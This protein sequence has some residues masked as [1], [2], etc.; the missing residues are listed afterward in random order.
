MPNEKSLA[1]KLTTL[2]PV[3]KT[4]NYFPYV[5]INKNGQ[6][7][8][9]YKSEF[10]LYTDCIDLNINVQSLPELMKEWFL[11]DCLNYQNVSEFLQS[12]GIDDILNPKQFMDLM[13]GKAY[14]SEPLLKFVYEI[15]PFGIAKD[16]I[17]SLNNNASHGKNCKYCIYI[18][19]EAMLL[20]RQ[21]KQKIKQEKIRLKKLERYANLKN[22]R[23]QKLPAFKAFNRHKTLCAMGPGFAIK[24][25]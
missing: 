4:T 11:Y 5:I 21:E 16:K 23:D 25:R 17:K 6:V 1:E 22:L 7:V 14:L 8:G 2:K 13:S 3:A 12:A 24:T 19:E 15:L 18:S 9:L 20:K 10:D